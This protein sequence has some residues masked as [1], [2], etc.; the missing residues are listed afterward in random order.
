LVRILAVPRTCIKTNHGQIFGSPLFHLDQHHPSSFH[1]TALP[2]GL[3][4][5]ASPCLTLHSLEP[6]AL[7]STG[8]SRLATRSL[9]ASVTSKPPLSPRQLPSTPPRYIP[10]AL[11]RTI[12]HHRRATHP[13]PAAHLGTPHVLNEHWCFTE[14]STVLPWLRAVTV[15]L[16]DSVELMLG[17]TMLVLQ[18]LDCPVESDSCS[19]S[20]FVFIYFVPESMHM[21]V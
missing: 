3:H 19:S 17:V 15:Q 7:A 9:S 16:F 11:G 13:R 14:D 10:R 6:I 5:L 2:P 18:A 21:N 20:W 1:T 12:P 8:T 4:L